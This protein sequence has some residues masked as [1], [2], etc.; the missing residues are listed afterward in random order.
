MPVYC[1]S[2]GRTFDFWREL[3]ERRAERNGFVG[4]RLCADCQDYL[5]VDEESFVFTGGEVDDE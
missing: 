3:I 2:C 1:I 4:Q 5:T